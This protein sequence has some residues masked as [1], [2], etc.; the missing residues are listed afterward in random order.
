MRL[1][2]NSWPLVAVALSLLTGANDAASAGSLRRAWSNN[3][4]DRVAPG[5]VE[6]SNSLQ[7][8]FPPSRGQFP[9]FPDADDRGDFEEDVEDCADEDNRRDRRECFKDLRSDRIDD[10]EELEE[11][12]QDCFNEDNR[13][14]RQDCLEDLHD[15][16]NDDWD[17]SPPD[18]NSIR[19]PRPILRHL[20]SQ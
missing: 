8:Q 14:D 7:A 4:A 5:V 17:S 1:I 13:D 3:S 20:R 9:P 10:R 18:L 19:P 11:D 16:R 12:V 15:D 6:R 2:S